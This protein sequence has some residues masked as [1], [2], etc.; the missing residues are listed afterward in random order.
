MFT[1][2]IQSWDA[3]ILETVLRSNVSTIKVMDPDPE[4]IK[5][6]LEQNPNLTVLVRPWLGGPDEGQ[7]H[8]IEDPNGGQKV[9][10]K[11]LRDFSAIRQLMAEGSLYAEAVNEPH[12]RFMWDDARKYASF[13][14]QFSRHCGR[15]GIIPVGF[16]FAPGNLPGLGWKGAENPNH[17]GPYETF[18]DSLVAQ[19]QWQEEA[20]AALNEVNV[21]GKKGVKGLHGYGRDDL[22]TEPSRSYGVLRYRFDDEALAKMG[23][24]ISTWLSEFG[25]DQGFMGPAVPAELRGYKSIPI[26]PEQ[27]AEQMKGIFAE[28][29]LDKAVL[30]GVALF[31]MGHDWFTYSVKNEASVMNVFNEANSAYRLNL[32]VDPPEGVGRVPKETKIS[33][34]YPHRVSGGDMLTAY[35]HATGIDGNGFITAIVGLPQNM[36]G[37]EY[38]VST[39][40]RGIAI[41]ADGFFSVAIQVPVVS[42]ELPNAFLQLTTLELDDNGTPITTDD[43]VDGV[44]V[45][46]PLEII[47]MAQAEVVVSPT[48]VPVP[49]PVATVLPLQYDLIWTNL[50]QNAK[51]AN[52]VNDTT[53]EEEMVKVQE[54]IKFKKGEPVANPFSPRKV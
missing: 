43:I 17:R 35:G 4:P 30:I 47:K 25:L 36:D 42:Q 18:V 14:A 9:V 26:S 28:M 15:N 12:T 54:Y 44:N 38:G 6:L 52:E 34:S 29:M 24:F 51:W 8:W 21:K 33:L 2:H 32:P 37:P 7:S 11:V 13:N 45:V 40:Q 22:R 39:N 49:T 19:W 50:G 20:L 3:E 41:D 46:F 10:E 1:H 53:I 5:R 27:Y 48:P 16:S 23:Y 31:S